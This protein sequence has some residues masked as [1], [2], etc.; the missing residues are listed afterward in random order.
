[1]VTKTPTT[2]TLKPVEEAFMSD[3]LEA[4][5]AGIKHVSA[6]HSV[7]IQ[8]DRYKS[9]RAIA[10]QAFSEY[11]EAGTFEELVER[12]SANVGNL[13]SGWMLT[14]EAEKA[15]KAGKPV[16]KTPAK[17]PVRTAPAA[18]AKK[19]ASA[20]RTTRK[21]STVATPESVIIA[22]ERHVER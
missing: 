21:G 5:D 4:I 18:T 19:P 7:N 22:E 15:R 20:K 10:F 6:T 9:M 3:L 2:E 12:A 11:F 1:M 13:P 16:V 8:K 14:A 17:A